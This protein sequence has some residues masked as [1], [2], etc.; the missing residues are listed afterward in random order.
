MA[1]L[2][3][4]T[5]QVNP[6]PSRSWQVHSAPLVSRY[7]TFSNSAFAALRRSRSAIM[8]LVSTF[9]QVHEAHGHFCLSVSLL[10]LVPSFVVDYGFN[11][12]QA[13]PTIP[14]T[15]TAPRPTKNPYTPNSP[16]SAP[17]ESD[18]AEAVRYFSSQPFS[19][20]NIDC[21]MY[22]TID[23]TTKKPTISKINILCS[24]YIPARPTGD[25][26]GEVCGG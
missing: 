2:P 3:W 5:L 7:S 12:L 11:R 20:K 17:N 26:A 25:R 23:N 14:P 19:L 8:W 4:Q 18:N 22:K 13:T 10:I 15:A 1:A 24:P 16:Q 21:S 9:I 6:V